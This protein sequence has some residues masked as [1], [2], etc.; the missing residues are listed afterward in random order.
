MSFIRSDGRPR[1]ETVRVAAAALVLCVGMAGAAPEQAS[2]TPSEDGANVPD[3]AAAREA[4]ATAAGSTAAP[5]TADMGAFCP[6]TTGRWWDDYAAIEC[7]ARLARHDVDTPLPVEEA[8]SLDLGALPPYAVVDVDA[9]DAAL[10]AYELRLVEERM[11]REAAEAAERE[12]ARL[13]R[14]IST[15]APVRRERPGQP[16]SDATI[17]RVLDECGYHDVSPRSYEEQDRHRVQVD[18]CIESTMPGY[19]DWVRAVER[20]MFGERPLTPAEQAAQDAEDARLLAEWE[21]WLAEAHRKEE[22]ARAR[23]EERKE[24]A[25]QEIRDTCPHGG[26]ASPTVAFASSYDE[27]DY[28]VTCNPAPG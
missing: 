22:A 21:A 4:I 7:A 2:A 9:V 11:E 23:H 13:A 15:R 28:I 14:T 18:A 25:R 1:R 10:A 26:Y 16:Y 17:S 6:R 20:E 5:T 27:V 19:W 3:G 8:R 24:R 12:A